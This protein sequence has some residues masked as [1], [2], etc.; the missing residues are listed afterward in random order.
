MKPRYEKPLTLEE[1]AVRPDSEIDFSDIPAMGEEFWKNAKLTPPRIKPNVSLR[2][3]EDVVAF[4]KA[5]NPKGFTGRMAAVLTAYVA[6]H[7][8]K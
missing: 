4:F 1:L 3:P 2:V 6:A 7:Q 8:E 5:E